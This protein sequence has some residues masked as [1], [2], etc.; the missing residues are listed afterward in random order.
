MKVLLFTLTVL[1]IFTGCSRPVA[2]DVSYGRCIITGVVY[3][4]VGQKHTLQ[5]DPE[6]KITTNCNTKYTV[7]HEMSVGDTIIVKTIRY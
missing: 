6:W 4:G 7:H 1:C 5:T 2:K 3:Y